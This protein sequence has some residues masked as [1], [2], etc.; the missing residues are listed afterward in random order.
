MYIPAEKITSYYHEV[1]I[2]I[3]KGRSW[4]GR[5]WRGRSWRVFRII[6]ELS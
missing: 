3:R 5:S 6:R 1:E 2:S 4:K